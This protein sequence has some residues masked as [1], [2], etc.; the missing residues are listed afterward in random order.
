MVKGANVSITNTKKWILELLEVFGLQ[1]HL[2]K[3]PFY[4][5]TKI[6]L[7][8]L[9][10]SKQKLSDQRSKVNNFGVIFL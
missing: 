4:T 7:W 5:S 1:Y 2:K 9:L 10:L 8:Y 3:S 6:K